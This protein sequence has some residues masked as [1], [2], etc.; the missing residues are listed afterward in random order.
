MLSPNG[1]LPTLKIKESNKHSVLNLIR[2][3]SEGISRAGLARELGLSRAAITSIINDLMELG[4]VRETSTGPVTGGRRSKLLGI[5]PQN[6]YVV[7]VDIGATHLGLVLADLSAQVLDEI[8]VGFDVKKGP[9]ICLPQV[10]ELLCQLIETANLSLGDIR[11][12]GVGV[13]GPVVEQAGAVIAPPI[14]PGWDHFPIRDHLTTLWNCPVALNN[15]AE[16][17]ALGEWAYGAGRGEPYL[18]YIKVG[19]G[20]GAGLLINGQV[21]RGATGSA[22]EIGHITINDQ[23]P[24]CTCGNV[25]CLEALAGGRAIA[26]R[27]KLAIQQGRPRTQL[28]LVKPVEAMSAIDVAS[29]AQMGDI[30]A[31]EIIAEAGEY[32]GIAIASLINIVN[33]GMVIIGGGVARMGDLFLEPIR[34]SVRKRSLEAAVNTLR[35]TAATLG[36][37]STSMGS[38]VQ[39]LSIALCTITEPKTELNHE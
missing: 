17:G 4:V 25:G 38:V 34:S 22:G 32:L 29:A 8:V 7:G 11:A 6:G 30:F 14:M 13:P 3:T 18:L 16:L 35:I 15:D 33:P 20:V 19:Y 28:A 9:E 23:G 36:R 24:L 27:A 21:Y 26:E 39:A 37:R 2:F 12:I 5:N 1:L 10:D 31:Q